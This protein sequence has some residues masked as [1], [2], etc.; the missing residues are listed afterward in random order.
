MATQISKSSADYQLLT[1]L[2][3]IHGNEPQSEFDTSVYPGLISVHAELGLLES[4]LWKG[5]EKYFVK[6][7]QEVVQALINN[8][9]NVK[10]MLPF[11]EAY[12]CNYLER[13][14]SF[15][16]QHISKAHKNPTSHWKR[17]L[18]KL[19]TNIYLKEITS[20]VFEFIK[21]M[22]DEDA[23]TNVQTILSE[24]KSKASPQDV[25]WIS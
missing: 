6:N 14:I 5:L 18:D 4:H 15:I 12:S 25:R 23:A 22:D 10:N 9:E 1:F 20:S 11:L 16:S 17:R 2:S 19:K 24:V 21:L 3:S 13:Y 7:L 8:V